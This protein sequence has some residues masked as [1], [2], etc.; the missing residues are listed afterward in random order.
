[1]W[2]ALHH[3]Y[4]VGNAHALQHDNGTVVSLAA[5]DLG[6]LEGLCQLPADLHRR[7][8]RTPGVL[9]DHR[10]AGRAQLLQLIRGQPHQV[11]TVHHHAAAADDAIARQIANRGEGCR[12]LAATR[13]THQAIGSCPADA[14]I[15]AP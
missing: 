11:T 13:F 15:E 7:V 3:L 5:A 10:N 1:M 2:I 4:R 14:Q 9:I 8:E 12:R 6:E